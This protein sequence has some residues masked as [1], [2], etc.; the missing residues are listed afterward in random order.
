MLLLKDAQRTNL[1]GDYLKSCMMCLCGR[2]SQGD[3]GAVLLVFAA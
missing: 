1:F 2:F 3:A